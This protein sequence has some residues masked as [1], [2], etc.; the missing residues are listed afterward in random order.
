MMCCVVLRCVV[1]VWCVVVGA[2]V[3]PA[4]VIVDVCPSGSKASV[5]VAAA[6]VVDVA[7]AAV[8]VVV[9]LCS[10]NRDPTTHAGRQ[11]TRLFLA[12]APKS[13]SRARGVEMAGGETGKAGGAV[14]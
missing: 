4:A 7:A 12:K 2:A 6:V 3:V 9:E 1:F 13:P 5:V 10:V 11:C 14:G 8:G